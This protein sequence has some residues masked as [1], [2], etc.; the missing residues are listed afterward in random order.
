MARSLYSLFPLSCTHHLHPQADIPSP[1]R[2]GDRALAFV[3]VVADSLDGRSTCGQDGQAACPT[4]TVT[5]YTGNQT[6]LQRM[7]EETLARFDAGDAS[8][9]DLMRAT[10]VRGGGL[11]STCSHMI[12]SKTN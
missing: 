9:M 10:V 7:L 3:V 8:A 4:A 6:A 1:G 11:P 12:T 5:P 2:C